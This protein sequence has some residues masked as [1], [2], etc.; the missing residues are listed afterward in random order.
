MHNRLTRTSARVAIGLLFFQ[1]A[2]CSSVGVDKLWPFDNN[3]GSGDIRLPADT[4]QY[5]CAGGKRFQVR[6]VDNGNM[7]WLIYPDREV[8]LTKAS[9]SRY[10]NG[11]AVLEINAAESTLSDGAGIAYTGCKALASKR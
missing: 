2:A 9:G 4:A 7:V 11:V 3:S 8:S 1:L 10:T 5:Q 6:T